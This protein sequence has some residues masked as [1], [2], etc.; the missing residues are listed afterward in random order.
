M[1]PHPQ[2]NQSNKQ[3]KTC[4]YENVITFDVFFFTISFS[5]I[6]HRFSFFTTLLKSCKI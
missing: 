4:N 2:K 1:D 5:I 3:T 6:C